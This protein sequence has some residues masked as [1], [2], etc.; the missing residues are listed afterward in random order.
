MKIFIEHA[1]TLN[2]K[3]GTFVRNSHKEYQRYAKWND[4]ITSI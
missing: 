1:S 4:H 2:I 3:I